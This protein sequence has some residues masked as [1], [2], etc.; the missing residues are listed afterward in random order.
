MKRFTA[1]GAR[2]R[3]ASLVEFAFVV[4]VFLLVLFGML[5][6]ARFFYTMQVM[7]NAAREGARY[8]AVNTN[9]VN[10]ANVQSYVDNYLSGV[11]HN[12]L[13]NYSTS[14][15][16]SVY[17]ADPTTGADTGQGWTGDGW[18]T[19]VGVKVSGDYKPIIPGFLFLP[20][21]VTL[22]ATCVMTTE[23]N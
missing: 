22:T 14:S 17:E 15:N 18:G 4:P 19:A 7:N 12:Q 20:G 6:Y 13:A 5:E 11:G 23:A 2:R 8:A 16:I 9:N 3:G 1:R 10:S 21:K